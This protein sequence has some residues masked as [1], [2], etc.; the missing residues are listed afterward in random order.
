MKAI[1]QRLAAKRSPAIAH[2]DAGQGGHLLQQRNR[3]VIPH[4]PEEDEPETPLVVGQ[5]ADRKLS[6]AL[7]FHF[8]LNVPMETVAGAP[9]AQRLS[10]RN[11]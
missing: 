11:S 9:A 5:G 1:A 8:C 6:V 7:G 3:E 4:E 10:T 2:Q